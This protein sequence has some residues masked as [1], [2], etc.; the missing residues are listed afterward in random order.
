MMAL[1]VK[2]AACNFAIFSLAGFEKLHS[3][4]AQVATVSLQPH[5][6][7]MWAPTRRTS[8]LGFSAAVSA[9]AMPSEQMA[10]TSRLFRNFGIF[11][12]DPDHFGAGILHLNFTGHEA[13]QR[14]SDQ[15][16]AADPDPGNQRENVGLDHSADAVVGH[17][18]EIQIQIFVEPGTHTDFR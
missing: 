11:P 4:M 1:S 16:Q 14:T 17:A 12:S 13:H 2:P 7:P 8:T 6:H 3:S 18:A 9:K 5:W 10:T 15:H